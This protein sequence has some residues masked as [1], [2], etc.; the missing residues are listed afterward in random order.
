VLTTTEMMSNT[1]VLIEL[2][3]FIN[4]G[5]FFH[6]NSR[7]LLDRN[8]VKNPKYH[9]I[10]TILKANIKIV[11]RGKIDIHARPL[12]WL[13]TGTPLKQTVAGL[14]NDNKYITD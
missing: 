13:G 7:I 4:K 2:I 5:N 10:G 11:E 14:N 6:R 8:K 12:S 3:S 1:T 9:T